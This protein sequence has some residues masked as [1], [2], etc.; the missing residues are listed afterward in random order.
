MAHVVFAFADCWIDFCQVGLREMITL[1]SVV[2]LSNGLSVFLDHIVQVLGRRTSHVASIGPLLLKDAL[3][4]RKRSFLYNTNGSGRI[5]VMNV[6][7]DLRV[8][9]GSSAQRD[10]LVYFPGSFARCIIMAR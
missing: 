1:V 3:T 7:A 4:F 8:A 5:F 6:V 2:G 10:V 9:E